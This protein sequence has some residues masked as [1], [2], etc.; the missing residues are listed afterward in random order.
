MHDNELGRVSGPMRADELDSYRDLG[1]RSS[2]IPFAVGI[3]ALMHTRN[4]KPKESNHA[5]P[6]AYGGP[7]F[8]HDAPP[9]M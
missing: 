3:A 8:L 9:L 1:S 4:H 7:P 6:S 2:P 5:P